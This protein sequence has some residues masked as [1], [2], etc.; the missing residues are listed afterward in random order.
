MALPDTDKVAWLIKQNKRYAPLLD[1][2]LKLSPIL[3]GIAAMV[4]LWLWT[5]FNGYLGQL[6]QA[7]LPVAKAGDWLFVLLFGLAVALVFA[8]I[9]L[10]PATWTSMVRWNAPATVPSDVI[11]QACTACAIATLTPLIATLYLGETWTG[12]GVLAAVILGGVAGGLAMRRGGPPYGPVATACMGF[13][14]SSFLIIIWF[15]SLSLLLIPTFKPLA[16]D[17]PWLTF[18]ALTALLVMLLVACIVRPMVGVVVGLAITGVW[19]VEQ[20]SPDGGRIIASALYTANLG[21][22]R[23]ARIVQGHVAGEICNLGVEARPVLVYEREGCERRAAF[24]RLDALKTLGSLARQEKLQNWRNEAEYRLRGRPT[25]KQ[26]S[27]S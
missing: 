9:I 2:G 15:T 16:T 5:V 11:V 13:A 27:A 1:T 20:A 23:P 4:G 18:L 26:P 8:A 24:D 14:A 17:W 10:I 21:G 12:I 22:G 6:G 19:I 25:T 3:V 7:P